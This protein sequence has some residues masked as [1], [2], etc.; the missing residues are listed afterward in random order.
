MFITHP[1]SAEVHLPYVHTG[2]LSVK[3]ARGHNVTPNCQRLMLR[4]RRLRWVYVQLVTDGSSSL[5][6]NWSDNDFVKTDNSLRRKITNDWDYQCTHMLAC[7]WTRYKACRSCLW[8]LEAHSAALI[9]GA[10]WHQYAVFSVLTSYFNTGS[11]ETLVCYKIDENRSLLSCR[12]RPY[13]VSRH[14]TSTS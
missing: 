7:L 5:F 8:W 9:C 14:P 1:Y 10:L 13:I 4:L 3:Q 12:L 6:H 11:I 2:I